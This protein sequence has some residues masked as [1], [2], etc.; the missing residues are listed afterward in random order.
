MM[1]FLVRAAIGLAVSNITGNG[2]GASQLDA[3]S[4]SSRPARSR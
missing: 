2:D 3:G 1:S 4:R